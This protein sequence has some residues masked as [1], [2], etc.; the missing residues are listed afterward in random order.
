MADIDKDKKLNNWE[1]IAD[2][3]TDED[4]KLADKNDDNFLTKEE[5]KAKPKAQ[6]DYMQRNFDDAFELIADLVEDDGKVSRKESMMAYNLEFEYE[7]LDSDKDGELTAIELNE[8][9]PWSEVMG[10]MKK[11][12]TDPKDN[13]LDLFEFDTWHKAKPAGPEEYHKC[14]LRDE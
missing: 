5:Y 1:V 9:K 4:F 11:Y 7:T 14:S 13:T 10:V 3:K 2:E 6:P 12:D 8:I